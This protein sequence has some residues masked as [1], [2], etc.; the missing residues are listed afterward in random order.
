MARGDYTL[1]AFDQNG[2]ERQ[3]EQGA[4]GS[5]K[6]AKRIQQDGITDV[7]VMSHGWQSDIQDALT[8]YNNWTDAMLS[9]PDDLGRLKA[10]RP[11]FKPLLVGLHWPSKPWGDEQAIAS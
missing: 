10:A 1:T 9:N 3:D 5:A 11:G 8:Q 6:V 2:V 4:V 7:F